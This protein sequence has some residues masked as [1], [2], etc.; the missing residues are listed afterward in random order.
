MRGARVTQ[1]IDPDIAAYVDAR[2]AEERRRLYVGRTVL[3]PV[4]PGDNYGMDVAIGVVT[5]VRSSTEIDCYVIK[6]GP[7]QPQWVEGITYV[8]TFDGLNPALRMKRWTWTGGL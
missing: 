8:P 3:I 6:H 5:R 2:I 4:D 7:N 1:P